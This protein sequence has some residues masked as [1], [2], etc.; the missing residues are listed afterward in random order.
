M[1]SVIFLL[2]AG[3]AP[4]C[5][6]MGGDIPIRVSGSLPINENISQ[7]GE[8]VL[9]LAMA[10]SGEVRSQRA[11]LGSFN[12]SFVI[13]AQAKRY[14]FV[15]R[16]DDGSVFRSR[17]YILGGRDSFNELIELRLIQDYE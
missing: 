3:L 7:Y 4:G 5:A 11:I 2:L 15:A 8:C 17:E 1:K 13:E 12:T 6:L 16:C 9:N 14:L 10:E